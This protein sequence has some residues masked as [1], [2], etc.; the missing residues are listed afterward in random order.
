MR[1]EI[2]GDVA[3]K[4]FILFFI[5][6][7][8]VLSSSTRGQGINAARESEATS[9]RLDELR[10]EGFE[11]LYNLEYEEARRS[12]KEIVRLY[13]QHPAGAQ[14][15]A[16]SLWLQTLSDARRL[17]SSIYNSDSFYE[18]TDDRI[19]PRIVNQF[20]EW[21]RQAKALA[22]ARLRLNPRDTEA[23]YF[24]GAIEGLKA[25]F[26]GAVERK[27]IPA[28]R[29]GSRAVD[30][31]RE[32]IK[33]DP[34]YTDA[35][36]TIGLYDYIIGDLPLPVKLLASVGGVRGSK[37]RGLETLERVAK[38]ARWAGDDARTVLIA[39]YKREG[40][41]ADALKVA[42]ELAEKY[43][44]NYIF[45]LEAA[46]ALTSLAASERKANSAD[47]AAKHEQEA[48]A[49][50]DRLLQRERAATRESTMRRALDLVHFRYG[51]AL[52]AANRFER[53]AKEFKTAANLSGAEAGIA[54]MAHLRAAQAL[55]LAGT[56][57]DAISEYKAVLARP[58]LYDS[59][60]GA[61]R[62][63][64]EPFRR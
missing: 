10:R 16:T 17:Q 19:E 56:R 34:A 27:F 11:R 43:D 7:L 26:A 40:R 14:F 49:I 46:D 51:E 61:A 5:I 38:E 45:K 9:A 50:F 58:N 37:R 54:T 59:H 62:G 41:W 12:F 30:S 64:Q 31:H 24:S 29:S 44:R 4:K 6:V 47:A 48:F 2:F 57:N 28:L 20:R 8:S 32:T 60:R 1:N 13:P 36:L 21:T 33:I 42:R 25:A 63:L 15:L 53:A 18:E 23:L 22:D 3:M 35:E 39:L 52:L 55:D